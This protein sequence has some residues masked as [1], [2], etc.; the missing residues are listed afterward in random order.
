VTPVDSPQVS[1]GVVSTGAGT[2]MD[3]DN[4]V[5]VNSYN[6]AAGETPDTSYTM[7]DNNGRIV[8]TG[9]VTFNSG[10]V[11]VAG[12]VVAG[13]NIEFDS[14]QPE[15]RGDALC[16]Q[17]NPDCVAPENEDQVRGEVKNTSMTVPQPSPVGDLVADKLRDI[18]ARNDNNETAAI[19]NRRLDWSGTDTITLGTGRYYLESIEMADSGNQE[20]V[21]DTSNGDIELAVGGNVHLDGTTI[22][23]KGDG[24]VR[25][26]A[27]VGDDGDGDI[28][29]DNGATVRVV[30]GSRTY[31]ST[32]FWLYGPPT[33]DADIQSGSEFTGVLYAPGG[34]DSDGEVDIVGSTIAGAIVA[35]VSSMDEGSGPTRIHYDEAL[36]DLTAVEAANPDDP[37]VTFMHITV[38]ELEVES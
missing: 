33:V 12:D 2:E 13:D 24:V 14:D 34:R 4:N 29:L 19:D 21:L 11:K 26:F 23:V 25:T 22:T 17:G 35:Q 18:E 30:D 7:A 9:Q 31:N 38:N 3:L 6:S 37:R 16:A 20:L 36:E 15:L 32:Q 10:N 5:R 27:D 28:D 1:G 8:S